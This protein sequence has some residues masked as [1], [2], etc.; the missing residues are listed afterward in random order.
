MN[1]AWTTLR[2][3]GG[4][5]SI[6]TCIFPNSATCSAPAFARSCNQKK[7]PQREYLTVEMV[8]KAASAV[9]EAIALVPSARKKIY[10]Q[11]SATIAYHLR[12]N[13]KARQG[14]TKNRLQRLAAMGIEVKT[15]PSC[16]PYDSS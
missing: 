4:T 14:H 1:W 6:G 7:M 10:A 8:A 11:T 16:N 15:L 9:V 3:A 2:C 13:Q 12:R 5:P